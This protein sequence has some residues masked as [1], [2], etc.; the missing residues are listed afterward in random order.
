M[1]S[2]A[3]FL[4][5]VLA[6]EVA[7]RDR[8]SAT[9]RARTAKLDPAMT[10]EA[11][12]GDA[13]VTYDTHVWAELTSLRF[14]DNANSALIL[15]PVGVGKTHLA[16]ALGHI[17]CR[18]GR[19]VHAERAD[20]LFK[21]LRAARLDHTHDVEMRR[22]IA[23]DL[24]IIDDFAL[25][26]LDPAE[27]TDVYELVVERHLKSATLVTS[28]RDPT[29]WLAALADPLLAQSA[30]DRLQPS[31]WELVVEGESYRRR[32]K[33][34]FAD[35]PARN[36]PPRRRHV[37]D[38]HHAAHDARTTTGNPPE[39]VPSTWQPPGPISVANDTVVLG[40]PCGAVQHIANTQRLSTWSGSHM[41]LARSSRHRVRTSEAR[42]V[43][44]PRLGRGSGVPSSASG[45][46]C[47]SVE[48]RDDWLW[49]SAASP[50]AVQ[51][52]APLLQLA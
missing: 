39:V 52:P 35:H 51:R 10:L 50:R 6:D 25:Q 38:N 30:I 29:E 49:T 16:H 2:H 22:L 4:E 17:A 36:R 43:S 5:L 27:T 1:I 13:A 14:V 15:G 42:D 26:A 9:L 46:C 40:V 32:Q 44:S 19:K 33:P 21:R 11:W 47:Q 3:E 20:R 7:R 31:A 28:N 41:D 45:R 18:R 48:R 23:V 34:T 12:D 24:L 37:V 8:Q